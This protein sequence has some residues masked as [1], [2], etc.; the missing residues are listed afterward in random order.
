MKVSGVERQAEN[1]SNFNL[2]FENC[3]SY[4]MKQKNK[5]SIRAK[6]PLLSTLRKEN[7]YE[8]EIFGSN[9]GC[10]NGSND[11]RMWKG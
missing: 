1:F 6:S 11:G 10:S 8:K 4:C 5:R 7:N 2:E 9:D 3:L